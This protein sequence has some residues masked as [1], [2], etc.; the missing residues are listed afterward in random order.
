MKTLYLGPF[1]QHIADHLK[2]TGDQVVHTE[3]RLNPSSAILEGVDMIL[4]YGYLHILKDDLLKQFPRRVINMHISYLPWNR[5][6]DPNL[7]SFLEDTPKGVT[8]HHIDPGIDTG[9][10]IAQESVEHHPD[11]TLRSSY[12]RLTE[13]IE[14]LFRRVWPEIRAGRIIAFKQQGDGSFHLA[15]DKATIEHL[16]PEGWDT[17]VAD[18]IGRTGRK[19]TTE[20]KESGK[21]CITKEIQ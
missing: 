12:G 15:K 11:D 2:S 3:K 17:P 6:K 18:L 19:S 1:R 20:H 14:A 13:K 8:I 16:L 5:G 10:I 4:S 21:V 7:W 9:D